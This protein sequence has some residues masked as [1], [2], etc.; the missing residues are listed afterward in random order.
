MF[1]QF[2]LLNVIK[3]MCTYKDYLTQATL[4]YYVKYHT[5]TCFLFKIPTSRKEC[6]QRDPIIFYFLFYH[7]KIQTSTSLLIYILNKKSMS[8]IESCCM[9]CY[10]GM[11]TKSFQD[12]CFL[13][14]YFSSP[15]FLIGQNIKKNLLLQRKHQI[16]GT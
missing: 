8:T 6:N 12:I 3:V 13:D 1:L 2:K 4:F 14:H 15:S 9:Q 16:D 5:N 7:Y 11:T 10:H